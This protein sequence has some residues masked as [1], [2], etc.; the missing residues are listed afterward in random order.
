MLLSFDT[1]SSCLYRR[2][3]LLKCRSTLVALEG[4][5]TSPRKNENSRLSLSFLFQLA[6]GRFSFLKGKFAPKE[7]EKDKRLRSS[8]LT[9][10]NRR[11]RSHAHPQHQGAAAR[12]QA[13]SRRAREPHGVF[14][15]IRNY[16]KKKRNGLSLVDSINDTTRKKKL[17]FF[18]FDKNSSSLSAVG[19]ITHAC[20]L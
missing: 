6:A 15:S 4:S 17:F 3:I 10:R 9:R 2:C 8:R 14:F 19:I 7:R 18:F 20:V 1:F 12:A 16:G 5:E 13:R 11:N